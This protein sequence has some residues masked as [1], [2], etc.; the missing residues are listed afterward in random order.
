MGFQLFKT[1]SPDRQI[2]RSPDCQITQFLLFPVNLSRLEGVSVAGAFWRN[3]ERTRGPQ[4]AP[5]FAVVGVENRCRREARFSL[6]GVES[7]GISFYSC[8]GPIPC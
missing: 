3:P 6:L 7:R 1:K 5:A 4:R 2:T 8:R